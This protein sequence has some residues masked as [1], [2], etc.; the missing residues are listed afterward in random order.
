MET[1]KLPCFNMSLV[2]DKKNGSGAIVSNLESYPE[3]DAV[4]SFVLALACAGVDVTDHRV[5]EAI[6]TTVEAIDNNS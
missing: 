2:V 3:F 6:E 5:I 4:E 1:I